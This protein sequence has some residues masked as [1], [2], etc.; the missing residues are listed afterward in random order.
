MNPITNINHLDFSKYYTYADYMTW[1]FSERVELWKGKIMRMAPAPSRRHQEI[2]MKLS[3]EIYLYLKD[4][5]CVCYPATFDVTLPISKKEGKT[6]NVVQPDLTVICNSEI[7]TEQ[8]C[9]GAPD[10]VVEVL[11]PGNSKRELKGKFE[12]Y[13]ESEIKEYWLI[14]QMEQ[15]LVIYTLDADKKYVGSKYYTVDDTVES[16]VLPGLNLQVGEIFSSNL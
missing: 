16:G 10:L 6:D 9:N 13:Q 5:K 2:A 8:G 12:L 11:S 3:G 15:S 1:K 4:K 7:L 14:R